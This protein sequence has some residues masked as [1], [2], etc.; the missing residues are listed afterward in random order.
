MIT[1]TRG[2]RSKVESPELRI[3]LQSYAR[4]YDCDGHLSF[5]I[6]YR[7]VLHNVNVTCGQCCS[8]GW[9]LKAD[10]INKLEA[11]ET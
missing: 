10:S 1:G 7:L 9:T 2:K 11:F 3:V 4:F 5:A 8:A 6:R